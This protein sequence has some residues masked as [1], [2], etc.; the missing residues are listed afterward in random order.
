MEAA[1]PTH[2]EWLARNPRLRNVYRAGDLIEGEERTRGRRKGKRRKKRKKKKGG[3]KKVEETLALRRWRRRRRWLSS[4]NGTRCQSSLSRAPRRW[5]QFTKRR[6]RDSRRARLAPR[7]GYAAFER[8]FRRSL[9][10]NDRVVLETLCA[11][12]PVTQRSSSNCRLVL[13]LGIV[14]CNDQC[15]GPMWNDRD[16][17]WESMH[18]TGF[19]HRIFSAFYLQ[20]FI[21]C[22]FMYKWYMYGGF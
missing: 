19:I 10:A 7:A 3:K 11:F 22:L 15:F 20:I 13:I 5:P 1:R 6:P 8:A 21:P 12:L 2:A 16:R 18:R 9:E 17:S 4:A 14:S